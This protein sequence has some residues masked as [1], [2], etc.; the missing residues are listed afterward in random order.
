MS[1]RRRTRTQETS[2]GRLVAWTTVLAL[3][4]SA[5][6]NADNRA[7]LVGLDVWRELSKPVSLQA[8]EDCVRD[9]LGPLV[10]AEADVQLAAVADDSA[11]LPKAWSAQASTARS[12]R[13]ASRS[14]LSRPGNGCRIYCCFRAVRRP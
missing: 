8:L 6:L 11:A 2:Y 3:V 9:A 4:F 1:R 12:A 14:S 7:R 13:G 10:D 5:G